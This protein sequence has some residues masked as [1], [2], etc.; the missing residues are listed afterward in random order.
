MDVR[1]VA[2][3]RRFSPDKGVRVPLFESERMFCDVLGLGP[4]QERPPVAH[5]ESDAVYYVV[6][7]RG[8]FT[9]GGVTRALGEKD[10]VRVP[11]GQVHAV[12]NGGTGNLTILV[13]AAPHPN[14]VSRRV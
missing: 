6:E 14:Y 8:D 10:A 4:G 1:N 12:R 5:E 3:A 13:L 2:D 7:G 9:A 11:A